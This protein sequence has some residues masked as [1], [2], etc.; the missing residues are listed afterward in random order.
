M[1]WLVAASAAIIK[2]MSKNSFG[3]AAK[4]RVGN[5]QYGC[6]R[7][8][9]LEETG[10]GHVARLPFS[11]KILLENLLRHE[12]GRRV[13]TDDV[14]L[15]ARGEGANSKEISFMPARVLLQDFTGVPCVWTWPPCAMRWPPWAQTRIA[16][17]RCCRPIW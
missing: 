1:F 8:S 2:L 4:L 10:V 6:F 14:A 11:T 9:R 7:L 5:A 15:V 16:P 13:S 17:T 3:A 12:D